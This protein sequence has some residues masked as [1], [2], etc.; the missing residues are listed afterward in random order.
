MYCLDAKCVP[1]YTWEQPDPAIRTTTT[2]NIWILWYSFRRYILILIRIISLIEIYSDIH[3]YKIV[4]M[5]IFGYLSVSFLGNQ[6]LDI[7]LDQQKLGNLRPSAVSSVRRAAISLGVRIRSSP[8]SAASPLKVQ[9]MKIIFCRYSAA[10]T[11]RTDKQLRTTFLMF[12]IFPI[13][14][15]FKRRWK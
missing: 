15:V 11:G 3:S 9:I 12:K 2:L 14:V 6:Y 1:V 13:T 10:R 7:H 5:N 8:L 4:D